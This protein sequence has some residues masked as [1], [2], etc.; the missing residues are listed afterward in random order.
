MYEVRI[1]YEYSTVQYRQDW[2]LPT[3]DA[4]AGISIT[5][6]SRGGAFRLG[7]AEGAM[8]FLLLASALYTVQYGLRSSSRL[9]SFLAFVALSLLNYLSFI[10]PRMK[11]IPSVAVQYQSTAHA[12]LKASQ[13][14]REK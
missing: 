8:L 12:Q 4:A 1:Q 5:R 13:R 11:G 6:S 2:T 14:S 7:R 3:T 9:Y 10:N